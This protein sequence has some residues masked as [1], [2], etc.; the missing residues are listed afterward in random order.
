MQVQNLISPSYEQRNAALE[1]VKNIA[2]YVMIGLISVLLLCVVPLFS[3]A[4]Y[5]DFKAFFPETTEGW[6]I[7]IILRTSSGI[8][9]MALFVLFK[10]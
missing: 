10:L 6:I 3:G 1:Y 8:G 4:L 7:W 9:N 2:Y 5:G